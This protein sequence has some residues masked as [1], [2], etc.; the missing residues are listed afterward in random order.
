MRATARPREG[1][2]VPLYEFRCPQ[3]GPFEQTHAMAT[4]PLRVTCDR[5]AADAPRRVSAPRLGHLN[6][7]EMALLDRTART[8]HEPDVVATPP[9]R[10]AAAPTSTHPLHRRL[11][12]P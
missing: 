8:A 6:S 4:V 1:S 3:C 2:T 9:G 7:T 12:R 5:C 11:P 10:R